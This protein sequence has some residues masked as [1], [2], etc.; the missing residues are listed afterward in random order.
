MKIAYRQVDGF[1]KNPPP[2]MRVIL[3]YGPGHGLV[4]ERVQT[5][6]KTVI[7][8]LN[9]PFNVIELNGDQIA[10]DPARLM[11]EAFALS[12]VGG[13]RLIRIR[14]AGDKLVPALKS[15]LEAET[16]PEALILAEAD[17]LGPRSSLRR[18]HVW[19]RRR[20]ST[21]ASSP[22]C[23]RRRRTTRAPRCRS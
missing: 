6:A 11:D 22:S 17:N 18:G 23:A 21:G 16:A 7:E 2:E 13:R 5:L 3:V 9:D 1:I 10:E 4:Q 20:C 12:M 19:T 14:Q 15:V 8:D